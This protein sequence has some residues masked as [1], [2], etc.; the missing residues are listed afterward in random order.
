MLSTANIAVYNKNH[1]KHANKYTLRAKRGVSLQLKQ[2]AN[3][4]F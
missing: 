3:A 2:A 4:V 1:M